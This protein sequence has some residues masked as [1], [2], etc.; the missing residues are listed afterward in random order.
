[1]NAENDL[2]ERFK[3]LREIMPEGTHAIAFELEST[4][5]SLNRRRIHAVSAAE[6]A[7]LNLRV[8]RLAWKVKRDGYRNGHA[9]LCGQIDR[10]SRERHKWRSKYLFLEAEIGDAAADAKFEER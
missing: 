9:T 7:T 8:E 10:L 5:I 6:S 4:A 3:A 1:M 2:R